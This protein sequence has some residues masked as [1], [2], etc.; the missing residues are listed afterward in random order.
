MADHITFVAMFIRAAAMLTTTAIRA[1]NKNVGIPKRKSPLVVQMGTD[2]RHTS[3]R[4]LHQAE[5][6]RLAMNNNAQVTAIAS[7]PLIGIRI[8]SKLLKRGD[9]FRR[10]APRVCPSARLRECEAASR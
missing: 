4:G 3:E 1:S 9:G 2:S 6:V 7:A 5:Y 8:A 10:S